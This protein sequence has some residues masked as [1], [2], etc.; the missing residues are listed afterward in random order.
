MLVYAGWR[1][2]GVKSGDV[3]F[4]VKSP[5]NL[6][7]IYQREYLVTLVDVDG[8]RKYWV[9]EEDVFTP[10]VDPVIRQ[11]HNGCLQRPRNRWRGCL[12]IEDNE[13]TRRESY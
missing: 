8:T 2:N 12:T 3:A 4:T 10:S 7:L 11:R 6:T 9:R 13:A 1:L 5:A